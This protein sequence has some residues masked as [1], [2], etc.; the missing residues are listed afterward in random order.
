MNPFP[1][2]TK[3]V[4]LTAPIRAVTINGGMKMTSWYDIKKLSAFRTKL[5]KTDDFYSVK[6]IDESS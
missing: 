2:D 5:D 4:L 1:L 3:I 6:E